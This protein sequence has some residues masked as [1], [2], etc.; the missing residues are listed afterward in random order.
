MWEMRE[1]EK[2]IPGTDS[3]YAGVVLDGRSV[4]SLA[5]ASCQI[6]RAGITCFQVV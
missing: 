3:H 6:W 2:G 5:R 1:S 4:S